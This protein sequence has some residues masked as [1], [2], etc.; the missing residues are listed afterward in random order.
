M[1][2]EFLH[3]YLLWDDAVGVAIPFR[4]LLCRLQSHCLHITLQYRLVANDPYHLI[5][6]SRLRNRLY[7]IDGGRVCCSRIVVVAYLS[8]CHGSQSHHGEQGQ[9]IKSYSC[10]LCH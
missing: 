1:E 4:S 7:G 10:C 5:D 6:D 3:G 9:D 8:F 2:I